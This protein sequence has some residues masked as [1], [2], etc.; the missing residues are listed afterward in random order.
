MASLDR[1][2]NAIRPDLADA[3]LRDKVESG[4]YAE[5]VPGQI[6]TG[7]APLRLNP[8]SISPLDTELLFGEIVD[9]FERREGWAWIQ[10]RTDG[11]VGY[12]P[13]GPVSPIIHQP[14]HYVAAL[15]T[16]IYP[17]ADLKTPPLH[18]VSMNAMLST[19]GETRN[20]FLALADE[21]WVHQNHAAELGDY[22]SDHCNVALQFRGAPYLWGGRSS[23]GLDCS[24]LLQM[25][26][27]RCGVNIPRD[28]DMQEAALN[29]EMALAPDFSNLRRGDLIYWKGHC[30]IWIDEARFIHA[31]A[32]DMAVAVQPLGDILEHVNA[33][34][35]DTSPRIARP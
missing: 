30:G 16:Y 22:E 5:A 31:N 33:A 17:D 2:L 28:S 20:G 14:T 11:Y 32:T 35:N 8:Q 1:R 9:V 4:R 23:L 29:A 12:A 3:R 10:A 13:E 34:T 7:S 15:R 18:L 24:A 25:S 26:L 19:S 27:M 21:G 6:S